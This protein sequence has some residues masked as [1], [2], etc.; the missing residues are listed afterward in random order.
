MLGVSIKLHTF[1]MANA[2]AFGMQTNAYDA[3]KIAER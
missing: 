3:Q 1:H 2:P